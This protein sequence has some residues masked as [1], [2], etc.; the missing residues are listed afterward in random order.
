M[1]KRRDTERVFRQTW[2]KLIEVMSAAAE[3]GELFVEY[4]L[5]EPVGIFLEALNRG[6]YHYQSGRISWDYFPRAGDEYEVYQMPEARYLRALA[7]FN[8]DIWRQ[9]FTQSLFKMITEKRDYIYET[10]LSAEAISELR[11]AGYKVK[12]RLGRGY[13]IC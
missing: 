4:Q 1:L 10:A 13:Q 9:V 6:G 7:E 11:A 3:R 8:I 2:S 12:G 5:P